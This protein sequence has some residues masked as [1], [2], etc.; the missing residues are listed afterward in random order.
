M[1][2]QL[3]N[4]THDGE[5]GAAAIRV[6]RSAIDLTRQARL[7]SVWLERQAFNR[8]GLTNK[9]GIVKTWQVYLTP[10]YSTTPMRLACSAQSKPC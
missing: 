1:K 7:Q 3:K 10:P 6:Y 8:Y 2:A 9:L 4:L 5:R